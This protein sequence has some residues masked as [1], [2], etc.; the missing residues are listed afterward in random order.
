MPRNRAYLFFYKNIAALPRLMHRDEAGMM[1]EMQNYLVVCDA[2]TAKTYVVT[3]IASTPVCFPGYIGSI[4]A[5]KLV[6]LECTM[7]RVSDA[8]IENRMN[9]LKL[10]EAERANVM[11]AKMAW[12]VK[13]WDSLDKRLA[14]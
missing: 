1:R 8:E 2:R 14:F 5:D 10:S 13:S 7:G 6:Y 11:R 9:T 4:R 12:R 3:S